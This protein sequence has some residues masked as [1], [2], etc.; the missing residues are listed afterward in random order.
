MLVWGDR[1]AV[2]PSARGQAVGGAGQVPAGE[3][4]E[5]AG[6]V[7]GEAH[8][9]QSRQSVGSLERPEDALHP[10]AHPADQ[11]VAAPLR[12]P[13]AAVLLVAPLHPPFC[14]GGSAA[15]AG[16]SVASTRVPAFTT[17]P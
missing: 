16:T 10:A 6:G 1:E 13:Q 3:R 17:S 11:H 7:A 9:A 14:L 12:G 2:V 15:A 8:V 4:Q 5:Y